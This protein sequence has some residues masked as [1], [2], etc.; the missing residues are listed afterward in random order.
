MSYTIPKNVLLSLEHNEFVKG[1]LDSLIISTL[2]V[3]Y[4]SLRDSLSLQIHLWHKD[5]GSPDH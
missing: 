1:S 4:L 2:P 3:W 5:E